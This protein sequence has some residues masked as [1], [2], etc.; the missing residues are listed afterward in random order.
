MYDKIPCKK[1]PA[2]TC[3]PEPHNYNSCRAQIPKTQN[4]APQTCMTKSHAKRA[5]LLPAILNRIT[6]THA[7]LKVQKTQN[8]ALQTC[9]TKSHAKRARLLPAILNRITTTHV[10]LKVQKTQNRGP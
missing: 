8:R 6:T 10:E 1:S 9:M 4:R 3:H 2:T 5:R 7:E